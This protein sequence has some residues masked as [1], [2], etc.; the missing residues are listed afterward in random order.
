M[1][2]DITDLRLFANIYKAGSMTAGA[3]LSHLSLQSAS[4]RIRGMEAELGVLLFTRNKS[5]VTLTDV[6]FVLL[7]HANTVLL[8]VEHMRSELQQYSQ[9]L[10]AQIHLL[11]NSSAQSGFLPK[12]LGIY[13]LQQPNISLS[14]NEMPSEKIVQNIHSQIA[15]LGIVAD[16]ATLDGLM[17]KILCDD[18]LVVFMSSS[19]MLSDRH[20]INFA[21]LANDEFIGLSENTALQEHIDGH[22]STLGIRLNYRVRM[23][24]MDAVMQVVSQGA[25]L[26]ILPQQVVSRVIGSYQGKWIPL[27]DEWAKRK[28]FICA[29]DFEELP[30][31]INEFIDFLLE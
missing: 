23:G 8:Q 27:T 2:F 30:S 3:N 22:A 26:A 5:G 9:G 4:E 25:G 1:R 29:R 21:E 31:Y 19:N 13:L 20:D 17:Y 15:N 18:P 28:L 7:N 24:A 16:P 6:G 10:K 12:K 14:I 11:C